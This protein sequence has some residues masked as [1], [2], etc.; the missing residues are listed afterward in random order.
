MWLYVITW[1]A[2]AGYLLAEEILLHD[3]TESIPSEL[4]FGAPTRRLR[5]AAAEE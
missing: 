5:P 1:P 4:V 2:Q 3:L